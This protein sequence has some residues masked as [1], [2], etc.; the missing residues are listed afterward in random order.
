MKRSFLAYLPMALL[1]TSSLVALWQHWRARRSTN[2]LHPPE[3]GVLPTP[4]PHVSIILPVR[5]EAAHID[6]CLASLLAQDYPAFSLLVI[7]DGSSDMTPQRLAVWLEHDPRIQVV[8]IEHLPTGWAGKTHA[9]HQGVLLARSEW[10]LFTDADT[11]HEPGALRLM[12]EHALR[13]QDDLLSMGMNVMTLSGLATPLLMPVTEIL[14]A[15]R[16]TPTT[17]QDP[18]SRRA[19]AFGQYMLLRKEAYLRSGG[20]NTPGMRTCAV[21]DLALAEHMKEKGARLDLVD[22]RGLLHNRQWVTWRSARLGWGK[23]YSSELVRSHIPLAGLP[24]ALALIAYGLGPAGTVLALAVNGQTRRPSFWLAC[25]TLLAQ[26]NAKR[27]FD[28]KYGLSPCWALLAPLAWAVCGFMMLDVTRQIFSGQRGSWKGRQ[29][30]QQEH[31]R[32]ARNRLALL[33]SAARDII[34]RVAVPPGS[35]AAQDLAEVRKEHGH[36]L[37]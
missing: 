16:L 23:S 1:T 31:T 32:Q 30:P 37:Q 3:K 29:I 22:G 33:K 4:A 36:A 25:L 28:R 24:A 15:Q 5:N 34:A 18:T 21:E 35:P 14:L 10:L 26:M 20:Y 8:R 2:E 17:L 19:F 7:D 11:R 13:K 12:M 6:A 9:L 27:R